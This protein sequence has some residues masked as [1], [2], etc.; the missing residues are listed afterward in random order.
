M[1]LIIRPLINYHTKRLIVLASVMSVLFFVSYHYRDNGCSVPVWE[2]CVTAY[3]ISEEQV[4]YARE[5]C[6]KKK[7][8]L[9]KVL[10]TTIS[11]A[12]PVE[13]KLLT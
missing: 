9:L 11:S 8:L 10:V 13:R 3:N 6:R 12:L 5:K 7:A 1:E 2:G 4:R